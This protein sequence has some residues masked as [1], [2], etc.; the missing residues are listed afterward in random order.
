MR[1]N[2]DFNAY[3]CTEQ[4]DPERKC[5]EFTGRNITSPRLMFLQVST[6]SAGGPYQYLSFTRGQEDSW[7]AGYKH[8]AA[9][10]RIFYELTPAEINSTFVYKF[11]GYARGWYDQSGGLQRIAQRA[12]Q[13]NSP[14]T[15]AHDMYNLLP[16][17]E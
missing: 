16:S 10:D 2:G 8:F 6:Q 15:L 7:A 1:F 9:Y 17:R 11:Q 13:Y 12:S 5:A 4:M 3:D 14:N